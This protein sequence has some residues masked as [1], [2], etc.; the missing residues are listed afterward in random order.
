M[1]NEITVEVA[2]TCTNGN[3]VVPRKGYNISI[4]QS[5]ALRQA[6]TQIVGTAAGGEAVLL[7]DITTA[8]CFIARNLDSTN[9]VELGIQNGGT[10]YPLLRLNAGEAMVARFAQS[11]TPYARANT[12]NV[13]LD[14]EILSN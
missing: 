1:A 11:I 2:L 3:L 5:S 10:F 6:T 8:G 9:Y 4:T 13:N 14:I 12:A 7:G